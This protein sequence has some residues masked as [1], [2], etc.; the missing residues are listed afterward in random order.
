M[1]QSATIEP[2]NG[3]VFLT[4]GWSDDIP[5]VEDMLRPAWA[6][7]STIIVKCR[8]DVDGPTTIVFGDAFDV[9]L[10]RKPDFDAMLETPDRKVEVSD[11]GDDIILAQPVSSARTRVRIWAS[12]P[13]WPEEVRIG[14]D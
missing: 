6:T 13:R 4:G 14:L 7:P 5:E 10:A 9:G 3:I 2:S 1:M 12:H 11:V 8:L